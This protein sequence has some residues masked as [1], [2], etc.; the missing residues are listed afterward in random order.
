MSRLS[1]TIGFFSPQVYRLFNETTVSTSSTNYGSLTTDTIALAGATGQRAY[2]TDAPIGSDPGSW[3]LEKI[4]GVSD[5][6]ITH[7]NTNTIAQF[8]DRD[9]TFGFW[10]K[11]VTFPNNNTATANVL[12]SV[13]TTS[14]TGSGFTL[15]I[16]GS[17]ASAGTMRRLQLTTGNGTASVNTI[18]VNQFPDDGGWHYIAIRRVLSDIKVY[19]D[20]SLVIT[21]SNPNTG[22][23]SAVGYGGIVAF[24]QANFTL[25]ICHF[26]LFT[27][28][29]VG[30]PEIAAIWNAG[31]TDPNVTIAA[32]P[33]TASAD[34]VDATIIVTGGN[35]TEIT[36]SITV[37]ATFPDNI[38]VVAQE[39]INLEITEILDASA[40][41][42][43]NI[44]AGSSN[45]V[46]FDA[47]EMTASVELVEPIL[48]RQAMTAS[49]TIA[50]PT[51]YVTPNYFNLVDSLN[52]Y[53]YY[54]DGQGVSTTVNAGYQPLTMTRGTGVSS[55]YD[56]G[57]PL[58]MIGN[59]K[60]WRLATTFNAQNYII[61]T[62]P[63]VE[64][65]FAEHIKN[66]EAT[67][68]FWYRPASYPPNTNFTNNYQY[69]SIF[70]TDGLEIRFS[71]YYYNQDNKIEVVYKTG[72]QSPQIFSSA[73]DVFVATQL[74]HVVVRITNSTAGN[75]QI[76]AFVN[77]N[78]VIS[79][80]TPKRT[81]TTTNLGARFGND[82]GFSASGGMGGGTLDEL[83]LYSTALSN[84]QIL[85]H[86]DFVSSLSPNATITSTPLTVSAE[87]GDHAFVVTSNAIP[88]IKEA[89]AS[90]LIVEPDIMGGKSKE[91]L[92]DAIT[93]SGLAVDPAISYGIT[94]AA[95][96]IT[97]YA[98]SANAFALNTMYFDYVQEN[99]TPYRYVT[100]DATN[101]YADYGTD[102]D[103]SVAPTSGGTIVS[104]E[105]GIN[106]KSAKIDGTTYT[107]GVVLKESEWNDNWGTGQ[108]SYHSSFWMQKSEDD[109]STGLRVLW[110]LNGYL[111]NQHVIL[112]QYQGKL[113][114]QFNNGSGTH[115][116][117]V[118]T[119]NIN[120]FDGQR[121]FVVVA[122]DHTNNND[123]KVHLYVDS[124]LVLTA[125]LG[126]YNGETVNGTTFVGPND[127]SNNHP[128]LGVGCLITPF[129]STALPVVPTNIKI[130]VDEIVWAKTE[131]TQNLINGLYA[132]MPDKQNEIIMADA[133]TASAS[134]VQSAI[135]T[136]ANLS[137]DSLT[138][139]IIIIEP[140]VSADREVV[141]SATSLTATA[142]FVDAERSDGVIVAS[143]IFLA[144]AS[145]NGADVKIT[146]PGG[147]MLATVNLIDRPGRSDQPDGTGEYWGGIA[148]ITN[149]SGRYLSGWYGLSPWAT[150]LRSTDVQNIIP[151]SEVN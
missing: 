95:G 15:N 81:W 130:Y 104:P 143:D 55:N 7:N 108:N 136:E 93:G 116:D 122:F 107:D 83:A 66:G 121:H 141:I 82:G 64:T 52:P 79:Q 27:S 43:D 19:L 16:Y 84:S 132:A 137:S 5:T 145:V 111:D 18:A 87:S 3:S 67:I 134:I 39:N 54:Y 85:A 151:M 133:F 42:G 60:S 126:S 21:G 35:F 59:G 80:T 25:R 2:S 76:S 150:W 12:A 139:D 149:V 14:A 45:T 138:A 97:A 148:V 91:I 63:S 140:E 94:F 120:L 112:F 98:E 28:S 110:N 119:N 46:S 11:Y 23:A 17:T 115:L 68:E 109:N 10:V 101:S 33:M 37:D 74:H 32:D 147:P 113:H 48:A 24:P 99:V 22:T 20:G 96:A 103:Y 114:M 72:S 26:H 92:A 41:I 1:D 75:V 117:A 51:I 127:E 40:T 128:R 90:A 62:A 9:Y 88:E 123:N 135:S 31:S 106:G 71:N 131:A 125:E 65:S 129:G 38:A 89:T 77:G 8:T 56:D 29:A 44:I 30:E 146:I 61:V 70:G 86:Y 47:A 36:T 142:L 49:A 53:A 57:A 34:Q 4:T 144:S 124:V 102:E 73:S 58:D 78:L 100:F 50:D 105:F 13:G 118:T 69:W 6:R